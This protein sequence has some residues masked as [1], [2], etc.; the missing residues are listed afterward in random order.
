VAARRQAGKE[1][2]RCRTCRTCRNDAQGRYADPSRSCPQ[3]VTAS[4]RIV[5]VSASGGFAVP[6]PPQP[7]TP[8]LAA[9]GLVPSRLV[10]R[11]VLGVLVAQ[12]LVERA[13]VT[14]VAQPW[15][16]ARPSRQA[17]VEPPPRDLLPE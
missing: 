5:I 8:G 12:P 9:P 2:V 15:A 14:V 3:S 16:T 10:G 7:T 6:A 11:A 1:Q 4:G 17:G 13:V